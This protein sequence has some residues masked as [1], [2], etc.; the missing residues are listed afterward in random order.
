MAANTGQGRNFTVFLVGFTVACAGI[1]ALSTG[2][3]KLMLVAG[4]AILL[5][6]LMGFLKIKPLEGKTA[7]KAGAGA[8]KAVGALLALVG[9]GITLFGMHVVDGTSGRLV[10]ALIGIAVSLFGIIVILP[11]AF[12][13]NA[14]WKA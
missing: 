12:N 8:M 7:Q 5:G 9:W 3:G 14:I 1:A 11:A 13:K 2:L 6:S 10:L 4:A